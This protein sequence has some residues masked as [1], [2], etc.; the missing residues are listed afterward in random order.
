VRPVPARL[1]PWFETIAALAVLAFIVA[2]AAS[3][4]SR[5]APSQTPTDNVVGTCF[6]IDGYETPCSSS[7]AYWQITSQGPNCGSA[8]AVF[9]DPDTG[10]SY[11]AYRN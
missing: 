4:A 9:T 11:C 7:D 2:G 5:G 8:P 6:D 3:D 10:R 1:G